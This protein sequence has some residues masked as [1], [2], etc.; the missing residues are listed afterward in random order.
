MISRHFKI[1]HLIRIVFSG[2]AKYQQLL[3]T[4]PKSMNDKI[5]NII[6]LQ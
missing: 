6:I 1:E 3:Q 4:E 2:I 5:V